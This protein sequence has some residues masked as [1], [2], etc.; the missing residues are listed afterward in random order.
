MNYNNKWLI[1]KFE[2][3]EQLKYIFFWGH[4]AS[5]DGRVTQ[6][7]FSQWWVAPFEVDGIIYTTAEHWMMAEKA[8]LFGDDA[9]LKK[10]LAAQSPAAAKNQGRLVADFDPVTWDAHKADI[11]VNGNLHKFGQHVDLKEFL[12]KTGDRILV[13]A[14]PVDR[15]WGIGMAKDNE[16]IENP[17]KWR[18]ENLLGY[19]LMTVR[20]QLKT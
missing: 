6:S 4:T 20:E 10:I 13:E 15:I 19:A 2:R 8:R 9:T 1:K 16:H 17:L 12:L 7:F 11:V 5:P 14:S 3:G 18:G